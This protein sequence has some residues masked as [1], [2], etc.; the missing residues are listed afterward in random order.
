M[1]NSDLYN[2]LINVI[3]RDL[4]SSAYVYKFDF[5][6]N[7]CTMRDKLIVLMDESIEGVSA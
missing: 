3:A 6:G 1:A 5:E 4:P 7:A 2:T